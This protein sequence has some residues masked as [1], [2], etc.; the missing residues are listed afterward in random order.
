MSRKSLRKV[1]SP[2]EIEKLVS[3]LMSEWDR[4]WSIS[5]GLKRGRGSRFQT[6]HCRHLALQLSMTMVLICLR[7]H[8]LAFRAILC[9]RLMNISPPNKPYKALAASLGRRNKEA[10]DFLHPV[11]AVREPLMRLPPPLSLSQCILQ[12]L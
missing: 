3:L 2:P 8:S 4:N 5:S 12:L 11:D 1:G 9:S 6:K 7:P 10:Q